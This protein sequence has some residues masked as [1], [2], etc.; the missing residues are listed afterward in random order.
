MN[1]ALQTTF[2]RHAFAGKTVCVTGAAQGIGALPIRDNAR[3]LGSVTSADAPRFRERTC[4]LKLLRPS[5]E[6]VVRW[7]RTRLGVHSNSA[8]R[9]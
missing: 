5:N 8:W 3:R 4:R 9:H 2:G 1:S 6:G 7:A